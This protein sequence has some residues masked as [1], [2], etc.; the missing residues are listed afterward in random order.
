MNDGA[1]TITMNMFLAMQLPSCD[2]TSLLHA[3]VDCSLMVRVSCRSGISIYESTKTSNRYF[4]RIDSNRRK[5]K[6]NGMT[7]QEIEELYVLVHIGYDRLNYEQQL[8]A[9]ITFGRL[10]KHGAFNARTLW[11]TMKP[12]NCIQSRGHQSS[13]VH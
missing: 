3:C 13:K 10:S 7:A 1:V 8:N 2:S 9:S 4:F 12:E 5:T 6:T 11:D